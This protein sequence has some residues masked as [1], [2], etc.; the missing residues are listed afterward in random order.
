MKSAFQF[1][2]VMDDKLTKEQALGRIFGPLQYI[3]RI[4]LSGCHHLPGEFRKIHNLSYPLG[5]S[6]NNDIPSELTT[7]Q[8]ATIQNGI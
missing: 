7:V 8:Y 4:R 6:V 2:H 5:S 1:P 3:Q